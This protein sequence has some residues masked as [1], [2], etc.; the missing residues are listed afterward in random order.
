MIGANALLEIE[1]GEQRLP[2]GTR[3][4]ALLTGELSSPP[5]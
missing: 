4:P 3:V 2:A 5:H 1:P